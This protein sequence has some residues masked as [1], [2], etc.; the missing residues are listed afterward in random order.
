[1][2]VSIDK[3]FPHA[4]QVVLLREATPQAPLFRF[5]PRHRWR[6]K[7]E[8]D[9][10]VEI[11]PDQNGAWIAS[12]KPGYDETIGI[13]KVMTWPDPERICVIVAGA[14]YLIYVREPPRYEEVEAL[15]IT[16]AVAVA[17]KGLVVFADF[18]ELVAY[19]ASGTVWRTGRL[20]WDGI[21]LASVEEE[22]IVGYGWDAADEKE[23]KFVV[24]L[25]TGSHEGGASP[26]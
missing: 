19:G 5:P 23:V 13:S 17:S 26:D 2:E 9:L 16:D 6:R 7:K 22:S 15:P 8:D 25:E 14:G 11:I 3:S 24:D 10:L 20:S 1:M 21:K 4:Y 18:T 12:C